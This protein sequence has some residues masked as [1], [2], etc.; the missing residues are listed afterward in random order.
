[1][2]YGDIQSSFSRRQWDVNFVSRYFPEIPLNF[3]ELWRLK[4]FYNIYPF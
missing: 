2:N 1:M 3:Y 4:P